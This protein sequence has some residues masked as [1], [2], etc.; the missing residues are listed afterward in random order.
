MRGVVIFEIADGVVQSATFYLEPVEVTTGDA[1]A[2]VR[3]V[4]HGAASPKD[5]P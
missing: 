2:A 1:D 3:R 4:L 5:T